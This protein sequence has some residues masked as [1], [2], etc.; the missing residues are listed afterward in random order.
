MYVCVCVFMCIISFV[1]HMYIA[2]IS[3]ITLIRLI[4]TLWHVYYR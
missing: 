1:L 4:D 2:Y 3:S